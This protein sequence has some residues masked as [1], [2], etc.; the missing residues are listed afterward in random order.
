[1]KE[2]N[3]RDAK[4]LEDINRDTVQPW[5]AFQDSTIVSRRWARVHGRFRGPEMPSICFLA[6]AEYPSYTDV[7]DWAFPVA[8]AHNWNS[9]PQH[10]TSAPFASVFLQ[11]FF[12][13]HSFPWLLPQFCT[14]CGV[15]VVIFGHLN[16]SFY[17]LAYCSDKLHQPDIISHSFHCLHLTFIKILFFWLHP[18][19]LYSEMPENQYMSSQLGNQTG[20]LAASLLNTVLVSWQLT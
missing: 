2:N 14:A 4:Q 19:T 5:L 10:V 8:A 20:L 6:V 9:L 11:A 7:H 17:F 18:G 15:T 3:K 12:F 16:R 1:M 13:W